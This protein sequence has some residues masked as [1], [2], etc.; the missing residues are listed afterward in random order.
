VTVAG[1]RVAIAGAGL[2]GLCLAQGLARAGAEVT[3]Y[4]R[5]A[6]LDSR[7]QGYRLHVDAR[8]GL[9]LQR[10]LPPEL[11]D[12]FLATCGQPGRSFTVLSERLRV[13]HRVAG[14][15]MVDAMAPATLSTSVHRQT[16]REILA[17]GVDIRFGRAV[18][19]FSADQDTVTV[20][21]ADGG[22]VPADLL[23]GAD[24]VA[25]AVRQR[26][27]PDASTVDTGSRCV[28]GRT[29]L[30]AEVLELLPEPVLDGFTAVVGGAIGMALGTVRFRTPPSS[31]VA[32][33]LRLTPIGDYVMW[34]LAGPHE[35]FP[36]PDGDLAELDAGRLHRIVEGMVRSWHPRLRGL[37]A[38]A[39]V[40]ET[41]LVRVRASVPAPAWSANR[42]TVLGDAIHAMSPARGSGANTALRDASRLCEALTC[43]DGLLDAVGR[44][45]AEM[46]DYG[47]AAV[48]ESRRAEADT[49]TRR[50]RLAF[51]LYRRLAR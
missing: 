26:Y 4:E 28:Y 11:F 36:V 2:G 9:A 31:I 32:P 50:N 29:P 10:C 38:R 14:D 25:S 27:L 22:S 51:W 30:T 19:G 24:G 46:R 35:R 49:G 45:E 6:A 3:V 44:Y 39:D 33:G 1:L 47:Y 5:D 8:A 48:E 42:V 17:A 18:T 40:K 21:L 16:L 15:P 37:V 7:R 43:G 41:F 12:A 20:D 13:L 34:A 23:V